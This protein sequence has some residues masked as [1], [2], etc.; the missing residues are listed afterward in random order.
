MYC[1]A[2][3]YNK[4]QGNILVQYGFEACQEPRPWL[5]WFVQAW[6]GVFL[7]RIPRPFV[8]QCL[9]RQFRCRRHHACK[10]LSATYLTCSLW[11][12]LQLIRTISLCFHWYIREFS[13]LAWHSPW[14]LIPLSAKSVQPTAVRYLRPRH[15]KKINKLLKF[16]F[17]SWGCICWFKCK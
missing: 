9:F 4:L 14:W 17:L 2:S 11:S 15:S 3:N 16:S 13:V 6:V 1:S 7:S 8:E 12:A 5:N 10:S